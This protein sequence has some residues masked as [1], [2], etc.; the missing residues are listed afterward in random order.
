MVNEEKAC[1]V[2]NCRYTEKY[3]A[4][5]LVNEPLTDKGYCQP[6]GV[7]GRNEG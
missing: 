4:G 5:R 3:E 6:H 1:K 2:E 7:I